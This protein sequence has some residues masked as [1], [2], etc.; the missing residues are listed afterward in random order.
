MADR[1]SG[2]FDAAR[3]LLER[4][5][6]AAA[7]KLFENY[8]LPDRLERA[9]MDAVRDSTRGPVFSS[10]LAAMAVRCE[11]SDDDLARLPAKG[12]VVV[13]ANHPF[14]LIEGPLLGALAARVRTDFKFLANSFLA[15]VPALRDY[16]IAVDPF[17]GAARENWRALRDAIA[18]LRRGGMLITFPSGEV[19]SLQL[20]KF[21]VAD[22][23]WNENVT[24][25]IQLTGASSLPVFFH[26][27][28]GPGF[29]MAGLIH[30]GLRT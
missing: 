10:F 19:S 5:P 28:N 30:P 29:Q 16:V 23:A 7:G 21:H 12:P 13:V 11:C 15:E 22:P 27:A 14:G 4:T 9:W 24:R 17:G 6:A 8:L 3:S 20:G 18:W 1:P 26:G 2:V 25:I